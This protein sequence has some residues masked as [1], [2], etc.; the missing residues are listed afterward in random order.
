MTDR[1]VR[2][3]ILTS[4]KVCSLSWAGEVFYRRLMSVADD[5]GRFDGRLSILRASLYPLQLET[6]SNSDVGKWR[7]QS[8]EA[9]LVRVYAVDG[10]EFVEIVNFGQRL[11]A[12]RSKWPAPDDTRGQLSADVS[13]CPQ[14]ADE[15]PQG[16]AYTETETETETK[17]RK[18]VRFNAAAAEIPD[19]L[20]ADLW[21]RWCKSRSEAGKPI[22]ETACGQ[23][24]TKLAKWQADGLDPN[25]ALDA[26]ICGNWQ[27]LYEPKAGRQKSATTEA[28]ALTS[29]QWQ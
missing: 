20:S 4:E 14:V 15:C 6:V 16:A 5:F 9:G 7:L 19:W 13:E 18:R 27:G 10:K 25:E 11:R 12:S 8:A 17:T 22:T 21:K 28:P 1:V 3:G 23:Q 2:S 24:L 29:G 26:A